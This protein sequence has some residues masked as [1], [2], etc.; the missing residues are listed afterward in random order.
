MKSKEYILPKGTKIFTS[1]I[2]HRNFYYPNTNN[3]ILLE[4]DLEAEP[5]PYVSGKQIRGNKKL[6]AFKVKDI[7][8]DKNY[9]VIWA[10]I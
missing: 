3:F 2:G 7:I 1:E 5:L 4:E 6:T 9:A 8:E 10:W